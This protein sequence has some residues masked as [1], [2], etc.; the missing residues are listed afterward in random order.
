MYLM[1]PSV[2]GAFEKEGAEAAAVIPTQA[3]LVQQGRN[4]KDDVSA[5]ISHWRLHNAPAVL[6]TSVSLK[7]FPGAVGDHPISW[8]S[9]GEDVQWLT[10]WHENKLGRNQN[11]LF[12]CGCLGSPINANQHIKTPSASLTVG[13][14]KK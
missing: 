8:A 9:H 12:L 13:N 6:Q 7:G 14:K 5:N 10:E 11:T 4:A 3:C 2:L 1:M